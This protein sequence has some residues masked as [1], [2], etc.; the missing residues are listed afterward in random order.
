MNQK[1]CVTL[2]WELELMMIMFFNPVCVP[3]F[4]LMVYSSCTWPF[5]FGVSLINL[6]YLQRIY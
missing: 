3:S 6:N 2:V 4:L 1:L 5:L